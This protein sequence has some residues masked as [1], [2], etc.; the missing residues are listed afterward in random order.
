MKNDN[1]LIIEQENQ[2]QLR[3]LEEFYV[4]GKVSDMLVEIEKQKDK[5]TQEIIEYSKTHLVPSKYDKFG[6]TI[7]YEVSMKPIVI[8]NYFFKSIV[9][10]SSSMPIYNAEKLAL[11]YDYYNYIVAEVNDKIGNYPSSLTSFCKL[12]GLTLS[13]LRSYKNSTDLNMR[14]IV[15]KIYDEIGDTNLTMGQ[16]ALTK[17]KSTIFKLKTQNEIVEKEQPKVNINIVEAP[18]QEAILEKI[19]KYKTFIDKRN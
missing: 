12:A 8:Q 13:E 17:E 18:D 14:T 4:N 6:N 3:K 1:N 19:N 2:N 15:E 11:V 7:A 10:L 16:L 9:P 5:I